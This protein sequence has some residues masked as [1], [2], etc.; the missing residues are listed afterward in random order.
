MDYEAFRQTFL[1]ALSD[2]RLPIFG[3]SGHESVD[4]R[5]MDRSFKVYVE[6]VGREIGD[7]VHVAGT[8]SWRWSALHTAR[9]VLS[10]DSVIAELL[11][12]EDADDVATDPPTLRIDIKLR[13][14]FDPGHAIAMPSASTWVKWSREASSRLQ[15]VERLIPE[16]TGQELPDGRWAVLG[17]QGDPELDVVCDSFGQLR[18]QAVKF[19]AFQ[20]LDL[21]R[22]CSDSSREPD[23]RPE[24]QLD[25]L[26]RRVKAALYAW[27]EVMDHLL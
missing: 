27:G 22:H 6:P 12:R 18:L 3:L 26:F 7:R 5:S 14:G 10:E 2:S 24:V 13:A 9:T 16:E 11:G 25:R 23:E 20:L 4:L 21:P 15:T 1:R 19:E 17:W 8:I